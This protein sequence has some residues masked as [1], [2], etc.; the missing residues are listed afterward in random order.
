MTTHSYEY[1][2]VIIRI[3]NDHIHI[4]NYYNELLMMAG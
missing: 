3:T 1:V 4:P 2:C